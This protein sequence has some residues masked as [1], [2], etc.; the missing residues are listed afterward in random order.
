[1]R[2]VLNDMKESRIELK[3]IQSDLTFL[4]ANT[5]EELNNTN[6]LIMEEGERITRY[7]DHL[8]YLDKGYTD[9]SQYQIDLV[10]KDM[11]QL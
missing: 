10:K 3:K 1:M 8:K 7:M 6:K 4:K 11:V 9:Y 2:D 5:Y